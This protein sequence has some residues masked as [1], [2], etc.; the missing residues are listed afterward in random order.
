MTKI[1]RK[2]RGIYAGMTTGKVPSADIG[3]GGGKRKEYYSFLEL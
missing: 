2:V 3:D 1:V